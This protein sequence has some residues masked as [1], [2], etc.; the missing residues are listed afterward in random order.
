LFRWVILRRDLKTPGRELDVDTPIE[1]ASAVSSGGLA[2]DLV[3]A[4]GGR[5]NIQGLDACITRLR[6]QLADMKLARPDRLKALGATNVVIVGN[7]MQAIFGTRSENLKTDMEVYLRTAGADADL[8][9]PARRE[10]GVQPSPDH[11][12]QA[13]AVAGK[14]TDQF[15]MAVDSRT[16]AGLIEA[17]GGSKNI[18]SIEPRAVTR[19]RVKV[20]DEALV[21]NA[22][23]AAAGAHAVMRLGNGVLHVIVGP[24]ADEFATA[25]VWALR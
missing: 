2:R 7:N 5:R 19:L 13:S 23:L 14:S 25:V 22:A 12:G 1:G 11:G 18:V 9:E 24:A 4:F 3:L 16:A 15:R 8:A 10:S 17:L 20:R 6:V 21:N